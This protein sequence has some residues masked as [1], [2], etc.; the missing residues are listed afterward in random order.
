MTRP[1]EMRLFDSDEPVSTKDTSVVRAPIEGRLGHVE[2]SESGELTSV[3]LDEH[4]MRTTRADRLAE[5]IVAA[6]VRAQETMAGQRGEAV[7]RRL[8]G[9]QR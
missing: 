1:G 6:L 5:L 8:Q 3:E 4:V 9:Y 2:V 7:R